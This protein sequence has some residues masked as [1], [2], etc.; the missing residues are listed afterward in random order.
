MDA[1][2]ARQD[3]YLGTVVGVTHAPSSEPPPGKPEKSGSAGIGSDVALIHEEGHR[4]GHAGHR[5]TR[6]LGEEMGPVPT[7]ALGNT[8]PLRQSAAEVY[9]TRIQD[10]APD[11]SHFLLRPG[12]LNLGPLTSPIEVPVSDILSISMDRIVLDWE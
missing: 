10:L 4:A 9:G 7:M 11:V 1:Y 2:N 5:A 6:M 12:R 8:G 3:R